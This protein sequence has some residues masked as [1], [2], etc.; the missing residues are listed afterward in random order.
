MNQALL[1]RIKKR[2][3]EL[4]VDKTWLARSLIEQGLDDT[5]GR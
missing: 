4:D 5:N 3:E 1:D 2:A